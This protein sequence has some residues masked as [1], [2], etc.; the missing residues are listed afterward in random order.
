MRTSCELNDYYYGSRSSSND[1]PISLTF[2]VPPPFAALAHPAETRV[3]TGSTP[4][5]HRVFDGNDASFSNHR[6]SD[7][8]QR[9]GGYRARSR[10][11]DETLR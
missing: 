6:V 8:I 1:L 4:P 10:A 11:R 2:E 7:A 3:F 9:V 5:R